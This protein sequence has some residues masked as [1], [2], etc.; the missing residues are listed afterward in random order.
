MRTGI[1]NLPL[2]YG[3]AP[4]WLFNRMKRLAGQIAQMIVWDYGPEELLRRLS[5][6]FWFQAFGCILGFD[7]HSSGV[8]TT[9]GGAL[10][11]GL[12]GLEKELGIVV[13]GGKGV[14]SRKTP[15]HIQNW[16]DKLSLNSGMIEGMVYAS[17]MS[18]KVDSTAVQD[19]FRIY[20]H[21]FIF[22]P[23]GLWTV[24]Q[25]GMNPSLKSARRYHWL[26]SSVDDFVEEPHSGIIT[27]RKTSTLDLTAKQ[28]KTTRQTCVDVVTNNFSDLVKDVAKLSQDNWTEVLNLPREHPVYP[29]H[30]DRKRLERILNRIKEKEPEDFEKLLG[31]PGVG[32]K[33]ILALSL[34]SELIHGTRPSWKDPARYSFAH[35]GKDGHPYPVRRG[36][37]DQ[38]IQILKQA[39]QKAKLSP[40]EKTQ[41]LRKLKEFGD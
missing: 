9:V 11:E 20:H 22:T 13:A 31:I 28:S 35:G 39:I 14:T 25:Q 26:S 41:T 7:W 21:N 36:I 15:Q 16:G 4:R 29:E 37:Y 2:H 38:S 30:F 24:V 6:P 32:P 10:K 5:D 19:G 27:Q 33:T 17:K 3:S 12:K 23:S 18:A 40:K 1:A 34:I 8:T